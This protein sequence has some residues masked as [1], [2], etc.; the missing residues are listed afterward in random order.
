MARAAYDLRRP[1]LHGLID[2][3]PHTHRYALAGVGVRV[4]LSYLPKSVQLLRPT[5]SHIMDESATSPK[6]LNCAIHRFG[7][8]MG[9][10]WEVASLS[11]RT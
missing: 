1:R 4:A 10:F 5:L 8:E 3:I 6:P 2:R 11:E 7:R 9:R